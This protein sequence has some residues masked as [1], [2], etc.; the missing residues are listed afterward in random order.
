[1]SYDLF[2]KPR[3]GSLSSEQFA[4]YFQSRPNYTV[5]GSQAW[6]QNEATGVYLEYW[7]QGKLSPIAWSPRMVSDPVY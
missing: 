1:M 2:L 3:N 5:E 7:G 6:Y 4:S